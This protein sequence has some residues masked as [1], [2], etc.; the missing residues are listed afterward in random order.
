MRFAF[1]DDQLAFRDAVA[2]LLAKECPPEV[3]RAAW[4]DGPDASGARKG[5][6]ARAD[7][8]R[9]AEVWADLAEMGVLGVAVGEAAGGLGLTELDWVLLAEETG[10]AALPHPFVET[11]CVVAPLLAETGDPDGVLPALLDGTRQASVEVLDASLVPWDGPDR[12]VILLRQRR[13][14]EAIRIERQARKPKATDPPIESMDASRHVA[15]LGPWAQRGRFGDPADAER[16]LDRG[17]L[18]TAAQLVGL[19]RRMLDLTVAHVSERQQFGKPTGAQQAVKHHLADAAKDLR[20]AAPAVYAP[21]PGP[22]PPISPRPT[23]TCPWPRPWP[24]TPPATWAAPPSSATAPSATRSSTTC[25]STSSEPEPW[26]AP[27][28]MPPTTVARSPPPSASDLA[29][30]PSRSSVVGSAVS[31]QRPGEQRMASD[32]DTDEPGAPPLDAGLIGLGWRW[33]A[34]LTR[35]VARLPNTVGKA[36]ETVTILPDRLGELIDVLGRFDA[37]LEALGA[38]V[39]GVGDRIDTLQTALDT[40]AGELGQTRVGLDAVLPEVARVIGELDARVHRMDDVLS[41]VGDTVVGSLNAVPGLRSLAARR[42]EKNPR[43]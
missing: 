11:V 14:L 40:L 7:A 9:V 8:A 36:R 19:S 21:P 22:W 16:A 17:A 29:R 23:V 37:S 3:V 35:E 34:G 24:P 20:F 39:R 5:Q 25:T 28:A 38:D 10:Y 1:T 27:G 6:G 26:P 43:S 18:G 4:P 32:G 31:E 2:D 33:T 13:E 12:Y 41:E 42:A 30:G 15:L